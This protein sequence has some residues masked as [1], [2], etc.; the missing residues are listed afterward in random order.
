L[1]WR[2]KPERALP[3]V[4]NLHFNPPAPEVTDL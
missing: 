2:G 1:D 4:H 3:Q